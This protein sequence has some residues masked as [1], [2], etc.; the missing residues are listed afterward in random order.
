MGIRGYEFDEF[1]EWLSNGASDNLAAAVQ[2]LGEN[3]RSDTL[4][5]ISASR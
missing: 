1:G 4:M 5:A 2:H 3:L